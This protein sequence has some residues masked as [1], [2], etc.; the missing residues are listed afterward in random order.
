MRFSIEAAIKRLGVVLTIQKGGNT[1][2]NMG[3]I[4]PSREMRRSD[5]GVVHAGSAL[6]E[7]AQYMIYAAG[8]LLSGAVR[9]DTVSDGRNEYYILWTDKYDCRF[10]NYTRACARIIRPEVEI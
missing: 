1:Y 8:D 4:V 6:S 3:V 5:G 2:S 10:C 9:G 7:P